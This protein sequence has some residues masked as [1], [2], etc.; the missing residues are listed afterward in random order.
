MTSGLASPVSGSSVI[1]LRAD[2]QPAPYPLV[3]VETRTRCQV[4]V[5]V[6][7]ESLRAQLDT[8]FLAQLTR[9]LKG[10]QRERAAVR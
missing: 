6:G 5:R 7:A 4:D 1:R 8:E 3:L 9:G 10:E 2:A